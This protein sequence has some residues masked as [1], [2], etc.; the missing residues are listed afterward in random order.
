M[1]RV[2]FIG[3]GLMGEPMAMNLVKSGVD[4]TVWNRTAS[5]AAALRSAGARVAESVDRV[6]ACSDVVFTMLSDEAALEAVVDCGGRWWGDDRPG[7]V[8]VQMGTIS[9][10]CSLRVEALV[11]AAGGRYVE[12]P[13]S[14]SSGPAQRAELVAM[15]AGEPAHVDAVRPLLS[16]MCRAVIGCGAVPA[17]STM[18]LAVNAYLITMVTGLAEAASFAAAHGADLTTFAA[19]LER[20]PMSSEVSRRK[21]AKLVD[22]DRGAEAAAHEVLRICEL[23]LA[24][25]ADAGVAAPL[26]RMC[27]ELFGETVAAGHGTADM[28]AVTAAIRHRAPEQMW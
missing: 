28:I 6:F 14:G 8:L 27:H 21:I 15:V 16:L 3:L 4:L 2:G 23:T 7:R 13:V 24:A 22:D 20:G 9:P 5:R 26:M 10:R 17:A 19:I 18:K 25:A 11:L 1:E 12:A